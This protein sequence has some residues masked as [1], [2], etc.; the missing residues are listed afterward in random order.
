MTPTSPVRAEARALRRQMR[1]WRRERASTTLYEQLS[2]AYVWVFSAVLIGAMA[3]SALIQ[4]RVS[5]AAGCSTS[6]CDDARTSLLWATTIAS[7][8]VVSAVCGALGPVMVTP[9]TGTWLLS[10]PIDRRPLLRTRLLVTSAVAALSGG[11]VVAISALLAGLPPAPLAVWSGLAALATAGVVGLA[12]RWQRHPSGQAR[13]AALA[14]GAV[15]WS[16]MLL[17]TVGR[18]PQ[19]DVAW[20]TDSWGIGLI[21]VV[22]VVAA[23]LAV[24]AARRI[25]EVR[26]ADLTASG[27]VLSS[28]SGALAGL[29]FTLAYDVLVARKWRTTATVRPVRGGPSGPW[30]IVW[31]DVIRLRR[32]P[33]S[34]TA[35]AAAL[36]VPYLLVALGLDT[37]IIPVTALAGLFVGLWL[38]PALRTVAN[39]PGLVRCFPL[40]IATVR[41]A[42]LAVPGAVVAVWALAAAPAISHGIDGPAAGAIVVALATGAAVLGAI[43]RL[44]LAGQPNYSIPL[45]TS[46]AGA[47]P[48]G[49]LISSARGFDVLA[50]LTVPLMVA[51]DVNGSLVSLGLC[52]A[53]MSFLLARR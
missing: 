25:G 40:P 38:F 46:P 11:L 29:D 1:S 51:P 19:T 16:W 52:A 31:R 26:R 6:A 13:V 21:S 36:I 9:A 28:I 24:Q 4:T 48:P 7:L 43:A 5:V 44:L 35:F 14:L 8:G 47:I 53:V 37:A 32:S 22:A 42:T 34:I 50:L 39:S 45:L 20:I 2:E 15:A 27:S 30:A 12:A 18:S 23:A 3:I 33:G 17:I 41:A 49:L 10:T